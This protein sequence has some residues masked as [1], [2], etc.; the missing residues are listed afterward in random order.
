M[1]DRDEL[2]PLTLLASGD[3]GATYRAPEADVGLTVRVAF[4]EYNEAGP[5]GPTAPRD[6]RGNLY[7]LSLRYAY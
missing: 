7:T 6:F 1:R 4:K 3:R 2:G 5:V